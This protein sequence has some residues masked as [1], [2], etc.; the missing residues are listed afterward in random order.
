MTKFPALLSNKFARLGAL[1][2]LVLL[3]AFVW[4]QFT[5]P[6]FSHMDLSIS[7][8]KAIDLAVDFIKKKNQISVDQFHQVVVFNVDLQTDRYLQKAIGFK[9]TNAFIDQYNYD[10]FYWVLRFFNEGKKE[11]YSVVV[12]SHTGEII[13][14]AF[15]AAIF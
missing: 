1:A 3:S 2:V 6:R 11:E 12:S 10:L 14:A 4:F 15:S 7:R 8:Q 9:K 13:S 5:Y